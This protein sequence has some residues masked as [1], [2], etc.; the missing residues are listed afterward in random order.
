MR[1]RECGIAIIP[2]LVA[3]ARIVESMSEAVGMVEHFGKSKRL[4]E[5]LRCP[6]PFAHEL[7]RVAAHHMRANAGIVAAE[8]VAEVTVAGHVV[9]LDAVSAL[10]VSFTRT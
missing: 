3:Y 6:W 5:A 2:K 10:L 7:Q 9:K 1:H 4:R 8:G